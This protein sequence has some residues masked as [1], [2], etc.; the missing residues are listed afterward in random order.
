MQEKL[1]PDMSRD[2]NG[3]LS[4]NFHLNGETAE[5]LSLG[6]WETNIHSPHPSR[7][8]AQITHLTVCRNKFMLEPNGRF[9]SECILV[10]RREI[11]ISILRPPAVFSPRPDLVSVIG[12]REGHLFEPLCA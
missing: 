1:L 11:D 8:P 6:H 12:P 3:V 7:R 9:K 2:N 4:R 10:F 5:N